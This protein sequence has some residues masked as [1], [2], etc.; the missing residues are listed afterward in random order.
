MDEEEWF[1]V[2][3]QA[4]KGAETIVASIFIEQSALCRS[5]VPSADGAEAV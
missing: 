3:I 1:A 4:D 5:F 2:V